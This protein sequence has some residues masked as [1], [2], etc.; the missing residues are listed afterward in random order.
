MK[1]GLSNERIRECRRAAREIL[2]RFHVDSADAIDLKTFSWLIGKLKIREGGVSG[3]E[4]RLVA[5][6]NRGGIIRVSPNHN[7]ARSRF[8][9]AHELGHFVLHPRNIMDKTVQTKHFTVWNNASE[10]AEANC[11][12]AELLMPEHL[13]KPRCH[14]IPSL[15]HLDSLAAEFRTSTLAAAFQYWEYTNEPVALVLSKSWDMTSFRPFKDGWP[16]IRFGEIHKHSA[17]GERLNKSS[18]DS[19]RMVD[20]P[21]Y[22]WLEGFEDQPEKDIKEDS[23][24][25]EYYDSTITLLWYDEELD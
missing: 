19:G 23:R 20:T 16:R 8:T 12:A 5:T 15:K 25:L 3:S 9:I 17:A 14:G 2:E 18:D 7:P 6:R 21:A 4:G 24:Y 13:F 11:F 1:R 22:A 10:E